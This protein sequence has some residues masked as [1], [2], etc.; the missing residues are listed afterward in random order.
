LDVPIGQE[1]FQQLADR[2]IRR[3]RDQSE[4]IVAVRIQFRT[5]RLAL[6]ARAAFA[7]CPRTVSN[8]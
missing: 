5:A 1:P 7:V 2:Q 3:L 6:L 4:Q 8:G